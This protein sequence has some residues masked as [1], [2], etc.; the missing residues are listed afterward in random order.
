MSDLSARCSGCGHQGH[1]SGECFRE[2]QTSP[3]TVQDCP[4]IYVRRNP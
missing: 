1:D 2:I 4:C 3:K